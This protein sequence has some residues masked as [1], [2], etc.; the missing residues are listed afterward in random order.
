MEFGAR[1]LGNRSILVNPSDPATARTINSMIKERDFWM[2][3]A[4]SIL[5][6]RADD[7]L[8]SPSVERTD[9]EYMIM[10]YNTTDAYGDLIAA[11]HP[12][13]LTA[14]PQLV[15]RASNPEFYGVLKAFENE[16]GI[17]GVLNTSFNIHGEP[18]VRSARDALSTF[19]RSGLRYMALDDYLVRKPAAEKACQISGSN[20]A[21]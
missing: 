4:P 13:D 14:R 6:E 19:R 8:A 12:E 18:I 21:R 2:P 15:T 20:M 9:G 16:T 17:G 10:A 3:F 7:Y 5:A 11:I 1:A